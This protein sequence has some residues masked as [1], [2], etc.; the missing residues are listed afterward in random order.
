MCFIVLYW[1]GYD[2]SWTLAKK[3]RFVRAKW[4]ALAGN[5]ILHAVRD[6]I[7]N[8]SGNR[9]RVEWIKER[10]MGTDDWC[11][12]GRWFTNC[13]GDLRSGP[14]RTWLIRYEQI[15]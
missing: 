14:C 12:P 15:I 11:E 6:I 9:V 10:P 4:E 7:K 3:L 13:E 2:N 8:F 5:R 1:E